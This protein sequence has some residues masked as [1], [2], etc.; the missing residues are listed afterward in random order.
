MRTWKKAPH[1]GT[2]ISQISRQYFFSASV[3]IMAVF[4]SYY[5]SGFPFDNICQNDSINQ[6]YVGTFTL[7][8]YPGNTNDFKNETI[9]L[10]ENDVD[11]RYCNQDFMGRETRWTFPFVPQTGNENIDPY[12]YMTDEQLISTTYF[13]W[14]ALAFV[15]VIFS[16]YIVLWY[17][18]YKKMHHGS[19][20]AV[21]DSQN[22]A[23][24]EVESRSAYIPQVSSAAFAYPLIA[25]KVDGINKELF[26]F[27]D[28]RRSHKYYD[29]SID[30]KKLLSRLK[31]DNPQGFSIVKDW[32]PQKDI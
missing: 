24:S 8:P 12:E 28:Q 6:T 32:T 1:I 7:S 25:C 5:W 29:L 2:A 17:S 16:K 14:S 31:V 15:I 23:Y 30:A 27:T 10:T 4:S 22:I 3:A 20:Q 11:Y 13:G 19:Y 9:T 21:G 18:A 26:D